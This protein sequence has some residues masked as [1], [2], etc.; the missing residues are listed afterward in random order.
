MNNFPSNL[1]SPSSKQPSLDKRAT[2]TA[3]KNT[4]TSSFENLLSQANK[5]SAKQ[6]ALLNVKNS[7]QSLQSNS[8]N[9]LSKAQSKKN[10]LKKNAQTTNKTQTPNQILINP[11]THLGIGEIKLA[12]SSKQSATS[13]ASSA[14][15]GETSS[16]AKTV[17]AGSASQ[18]SATTSSNSNLINASNNLLNVSSISNTSPTQ[19]VSQSPTTPQGV[20]SYL[21]EPPV[22]TQLSTF[23]A[24]LIS[25][26]GSYSVKM[27]LNPAGLGEVRA[28]LNIK[29][30][31]VEIQLWTNTNAGHQAITDSL[32]QLQTDLANQGFQS[33]V[34]LK[35]F[36]SNQGSSNN[37]HNQF[38]QQPGI[39][40][41]T[42][43]SPEPTGSVLISPNTN[44]IDIR[45]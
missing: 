45:L 44:L 39:D 38:D 37:N 4:T 15:V 21:N 29:S 31:V 22:N 14:L 23:I 6:H 3:V 36:S 11:I 24:P 8:K 41:I 27:Q 40:P 32:N 1:E 20:A 26:P 18:L 7:A 5:N 16:G 43:A 42:L 12:A 28:Q 30:N 34:D 35:N 9:I 17:K 10:P 25:N 33:S 19:N 13:L 2:T